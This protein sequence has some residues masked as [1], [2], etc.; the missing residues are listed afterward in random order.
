MLQEETK[1]LDM[2]SM[3]GTDV[4]C[5]YCRQINFIPIRFDE[6]NN[7]ECESC[8][9]KNSVYVDVTTTQKTDIPQS[10]GMSIDPIISKTLDKEDDE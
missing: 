7:F 1:R 6:D 9:K 8:G 4:Q 3:Q 10:P 5:A 2:Y